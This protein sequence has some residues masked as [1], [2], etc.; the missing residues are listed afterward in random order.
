MTGHPEAVLAREL[1]ICYTAIALV[2]DHDAGVEGDTAS[3]RRRSSGCSARTP[4]GC[5]ICC[6]GLPPTLDLDRHCP[7]PN[8]LDGIR[9]PI[10]LP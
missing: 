5:G 4:N 8:A 3:P 1:A 9:L 6:F 10:E 7:C 2:T